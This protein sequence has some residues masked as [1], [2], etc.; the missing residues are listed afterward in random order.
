MRKLYFLLLFTCCVHVLE[1][2][3]SFLSMILKGCT[4]NKM[5]YDPFSLSDW[6][7]TVA[8]F[9]NENPENICLTQANLSKFALFILDFFNVLCYIKD[10]N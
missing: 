2:H 9:W 7:K 6:V 4:P 10:H 1:T 8:V 5:I 3:Q